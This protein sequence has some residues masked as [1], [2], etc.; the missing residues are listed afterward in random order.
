MQ[1]FQYQT[2]IFEGHMLAVVVG[3]H[4]NHKIVCK[5]ITW[6]FTESLPQQVVAQESDSNAD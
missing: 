2:V 3:R 4:D 1:R 6:T 5:S